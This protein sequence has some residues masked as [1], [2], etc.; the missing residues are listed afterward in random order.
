MVVYVATWQYYENFMLIGVFHS[1]GDAQQACLD[2]ASD[3]TSHPGH[4]PILDFVA[5]HPIWH[6]KIR[7]DTNEVGYFIYERTVT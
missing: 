1:L 5:M 2:E 4:Y 6:G 3:D 7:Q